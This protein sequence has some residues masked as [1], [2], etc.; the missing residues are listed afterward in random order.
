MVGSKYQ[1]SAELVAGL[2]PVGTRPRGAPLRGRFPEMVGTAS[3]A[4][5]R[6]AVAPTTSISRSD[7]IPDNTIT[8]AWTPVQC[9]MVDDAEDEQAVYRMNGTLLEYD[10]TSIERLD[11]AAE[12]TLGAHQLLGCS[13]RLLGCDEGDGLE[14]VRV[15][16]ADGGQR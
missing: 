14:P 9:S 11:L 5:V 2:L 3:D 4:G 8:V 15:D 13:F 16:V 6:L 7:P 1:S 10:S 12:V